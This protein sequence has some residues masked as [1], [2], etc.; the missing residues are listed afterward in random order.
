MLNPTTIDYAII[1]C[2]AL[3]VALTCYFLFNFQSVIARVKQ[4]AQ[5]TKLFHLTIYSRIILG[6]I[7]LYIHDYS[8]YPMV[9]FVIGALILFSGIVIFIIGYQR[10]NRFITLLIDKCYSLLKPFAILAVL[11]MLYLIYAIFQNLL[12]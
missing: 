6:S 11:G 5:S 1:A 8:Q 7:L 12:I 2:L 9:L 4:S 10:F 3:F